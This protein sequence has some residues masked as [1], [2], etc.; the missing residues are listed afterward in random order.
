MFCKVRLCSRVYQSKGNQK[1]RIRALVT[2]LPCSTM[3][4]KWQCSRMR[5]R[6]QDLDP[7][8]AARPNRP[9]VDV[10]EAVVWVVGEW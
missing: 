4:A 3:I 1:N 7:A 8:I 9:M 6:H 2:S 10:T 5:Q